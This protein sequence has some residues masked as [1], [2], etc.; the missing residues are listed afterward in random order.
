MVYLTGGTL[1]IKVLNFSPT[2]SNDGRNEEQEKFLLSLQDKGG[3]VSLRGGS[4]S[5]FA[6]SCF[7][8]LLKRLKGAPP[9]S[10]WIADE[11]FPYPPL[12]AQRWEIPLSRLLLVKVH[13]APDTWKVGL[14]AIQTGLFKWVFLRPSSPCP[15]SHLRKL[16]LASE[17]LETQVFILSNA[18]LP[19]WPIR[20]RCELSYEPNSF[21][22]KQ[23]RDP[24]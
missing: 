1:S 16:Q 18:D 24:Q 23:W 12:L 20:V 2:C 7:E 22:P 9:F 13:S 4:K 15:A 17:R 14:E 21:L 19:H 10:V 3:L 5:Y 8:V 11:G 6:L